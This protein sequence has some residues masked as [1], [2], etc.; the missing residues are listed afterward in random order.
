MIRIDFDAWMSMDLSGL[1]QLGDWVGFGLFILA[2]IL[3]LTSGA[4]YI[5]KYG[6][7][8]FSED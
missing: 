6:K 3:T 7:M 4:S 2:T 8:V 5:Q 1:A